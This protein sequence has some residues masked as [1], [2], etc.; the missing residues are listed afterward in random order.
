MIPNT[1]SPIS[2]PLPLD[3]PPVVEREDVKDVV[4]DRPMVAADNDDDR[5]CESY[6]RSSIKRVWMGRTNRTAAWRARDGGGDGDGVMVVVS[7]SFVV[8]CGRKR[9]IVGTRAFLLRN[10]IY[11]Y[12][13]LSFRGVKKRAPRP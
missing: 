8:F 3:V 9:V 11:Y 10:D 13:L 5:A 1:Q 7:S 6:T 4:D 2:L 12:A